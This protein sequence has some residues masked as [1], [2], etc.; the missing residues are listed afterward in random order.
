MTDFNA[1]AG[2][3]AMIHNTAPACPKCG[4]P[5]TANVANVRAV[6]INAPGQVQ[7]QSLPRTADTAKTAAQ[8]AA[9]DG[10]ILGTNYSITPWF[11]RRWLVLICAVTVTP[12]ASILAMTGNVYYK[13]KGNVKVFPKNI[14]TG[15]MLATLPWLTYMLNSNNMSGVVSA[16]ALN[17]FVLILAFKK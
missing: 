17:L 14:K 11:R 5:Q 7:P 15:L 6:P 9:A 8:K 2:C 13:S 16:V 3:G 1:C 4:T 12:V 10:E